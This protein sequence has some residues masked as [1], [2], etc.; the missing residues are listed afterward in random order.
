MKTNRV[1]IIFLLFLKKCL[2]SASVPRIWRKSKV[3][4]IPKPGKATDDPKNFR[5]ISL[6]CHTYKLFERLLLN[7]LTAAID[8]KLIP[9][10]AGFRP[11]KSCCNQTLKLVQHIEDGFEAGMV[12]GAVFVDLSAAY[13][14]VNLRRLMWKVGT[15]INDPKFVRILRKLLH[16][17]RFQVHL[18]SEKS[19]WRSQKNGLPQGSVLAPLLFNIYTN[20]QPSSP[21]TSRFIY[22]DDLALTSQAVSFEEA[23]LNLSDAL[24]HLERYYITNSLKPNPSKTQSCVFHLRNREAGR[25]LNMVWGGVSI[26]HSKY[27]KYLGVTLDR[28]LTFNKNCYN[29]KHKVHTR[30]NLLQKLVSSKWG[31][32]PAVMRTSGLALSFSAGEYASPV[33]S[34]SAHAKLVDTALNETCRIITGCL[35]PTPVQ[36]LYSLAGIAPPGVRRSVASSNERSK[37]SND[38]R[39]PLHNNTLVP[40]RLKSRKSFLKCVPPLTGEPSQERLMLWREVACL[41]GA[42]VPPAESLPPGHGL[43]WQTWKSLN[44]L[45]TQVGRSKESMLRWGFIND[46]GLE[47]KCGVTPQTMSHLL[48]CPETCTLQELMDATDNAV[49]VAEFWADSI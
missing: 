11:A 46:C 6:L 7:R 40:Q 35:K 20:D 1:I 33:W 22:A 49:R 19:R 26:E 43:P 25:K 5:P 32:S 12:T 10:Q 37:L 3:I 29:I 34:R 14:T 9:E 15:M 24:D 31:A 30:N 41:P 38:T 4:A 2:E 45:R 17:R 16:N 47:C 13:D 42:F 8:P 36:R 27:P 23:E 44:R 28:S 39:H 21:N 18:P 48:S